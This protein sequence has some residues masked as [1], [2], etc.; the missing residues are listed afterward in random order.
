MTPGQPFN[1]YRKFKNFVIIPI[2]VVESD[3]ISMGAKIAYGRLACHK[4]TDSTD[5][6]VKRE[7]LAAELKV[8]VD[9]IDRYLKELTKLRLIRPI[10]RGPQQSAYQ[11]LGH[12]ML[13]PSLKESAYLRS[14]ETGQS[15]QI[16]GHESADLRIRVGRSAE[17]Y[18]EE[19]GFEKGYEKESSSK[20]LTATREPEAT[21]TTA[22]PP[23]QR[24]TLEHSRV[25]RACEIRVQ[26]LYPFRE[27][28]MVL[29]GFKKLPVMSLA[30]YVIRTAGG[31]R[32][33][34]EFLDDMA[35]ELE[36]RRGMRPRQWAWFRIA[37]RSWAERR[38]ADPQR[39]AASVPQTK[40]NVAAD[41]PK[42]SSHPR[43]LQIV[44]ARSRPAWWTAAELLEVREAMAAHRRTGPPDP[45]ITAQILQHF[46]GMEEFRCWFTELTHRFPG[47]RVQSFGFYEADARNN[48]PS[49]RKDLEA[50]QKAAAARGEALNREAAGDGKGEEECRALEQEQRA[51]RDRAAVIEV[52]AARGWKRLHPDSD[53]NHCL[54]FG[55]DAGTEQLCSCRAGSELTRQ[56]EHCPACD[57][58][59]LR[60]TPEGVWEWCT[61][62]H[63][64]RLR[65]RQPRSVEES[66]AV[67]MK[68]RKSGAVPRLAIM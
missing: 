18:K 46:A 33:S 60:E 56:L 36:T 54:G 49:R 30:R 48:W 57:D 7:T 24:P 47:S 58:G 25:L 67:V 19:K 6:F 14:H 32:A 16:C 11:F 2:A 55:R 28:M 43:A 52:A 53:C 68:L 4:A 10:R 3:R 20:Q 27:R 64:A 17:R 50:Q 37:V 21:T 41:V 65:V 5:C 59:G 40:R 62:P 9:T 1:L 45:Q 42:P 63:A 15:G 38:S 66:N 12:E 22:A 26:E 8:S 35:R 29:I 61:C 23:D 44:T 51:K 13:A 31:A 39:R 34:V